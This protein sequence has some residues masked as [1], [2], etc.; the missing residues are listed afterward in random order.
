MHPPA[1]DPAYKTTILRSPQRAMISLDNTV[2]EMTGPVFGHSLLG[3]LDNDLIHNFA[4]AG[5]SAIVKDHRA[6]SRSG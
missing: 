5:E 3:P 4:R 2:S 6:W 1:Y